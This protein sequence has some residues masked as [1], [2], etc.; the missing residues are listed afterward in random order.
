MSNR[1]VE[2]AAKAAALPV[3]PLV[4]GLV[5]AGL[6]V[7]PEAVA[8]ELAVGRELGPSVQL[9]EALQ[10]R[11]DR[12]AAGEVEVLL[13]RGRVGLELEGL[14]WVS[15]ELEV[16][17][18]GISLSSPGVARP[19]PLPRLHESRA[20]FRLAPGAAYLSVGLFRPQLG[21]ESLTSGFVVDS[22]DKSVTQKAL[23]EFLTGNEAGVSPGLNLGGG[24][25][26]DGRAFRYDVGL[27]LR[28]PE[29]GEGFGERR[30][31]AVART[32]VSFGECETTDYSLARSQNDF[33]ERP[34]LVL[35][36]QGSRALSGH[37]WSVGADALWRVRPL[38]LTAELHWLSEPFVPRLLAHVR[39]G[40]DVKGPGETV[41]EPWLM[42]SHVAA[43]VAGTT[44]A[45]RLEAGATLFLRRQALRVTA[46]GAW[47]LSAPLPAASGA[48]PSGRGLTL[49]VMLQYQR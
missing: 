47:E 3:R 29:P 11:A 43:G 16:S 6:V 1:F 39:A 24:V 15:A 32:S 19:V 30:L 2:T 34:V 46:G 42:A 5:L 49:G 26:R 41:I 21:R 33:G 31:F 12:G 4:L 38:V 48:A 8:E 25:A 45:S 13:R 23:R 40:V 10:L 7:S 14:S 20:T 22:L 9:H 17:F 18:D 36:A 27:A 44:E 28:D 37:A 35:A